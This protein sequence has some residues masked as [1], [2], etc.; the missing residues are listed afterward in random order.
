MIVPLRWR[1]VAKATGITG[2]IICEI[3]GA[4]DPKEAI[5]AAVSMKDQKR[6]QPPFRYRCDQ[7]G[8]TQDDIS[9]VGYGE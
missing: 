8:A 2:R 9:G 5:F 6:G 1:N 7:C 4:V 3:H